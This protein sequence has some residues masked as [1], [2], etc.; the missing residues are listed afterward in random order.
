MR[1]VVLMVGI[2]AVMLQ[3]GCAGKSSGLKNDEIANW[4]QKLLEARTKTDIEFKNDI[5]S[6]MA[7]IARL[8]V[9]SGKIAF[10]VPEENGL[11]VSDKNESAVMMVSGTGGN[12]TWKALKENV[13]GEL[14]GKPVSE[15]VIAGG[16]LL[17][18]G[19][20]TLQAYPTKSKLVLLVFDS[21]RPELHHFQHLK[22][23]EPNP[24]LALNARV[25]RLQKPDKVTMLTSRNLEKTYYRY[26]I[27]HFEAD[28]EPCQLTA[29]KM[30][31]KGK[32]DN[33]LF[34]PF[35]DATSGKESYGAGRFL[36]LK[37]TPGDIMRLD[38][39]L[40][41]NPLCNYSPAYN[42]P[43]PPAE[44]TLSVPIRAGE[45]AYPHER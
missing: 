40:A 28:G 43:I 13:S 31:L 17:K 34:I 20:F 41:F 29:Y 2:A 36:E 26:A 27:L 21:M 45:M 12:W 19:R 18:L 11:D 25:E 4:K 10:L 38:L 1:K 23:F 14:D 37:E 15:S 32:Y 8:N 33:E 42:C 22:Y 24:D 30:N 39:N 44:N 3:M 6:P 5:V 16:M 9:D 35:R 7:G